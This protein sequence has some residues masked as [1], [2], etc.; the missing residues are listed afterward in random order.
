MYLREYNKVSQAEKK[1]ESKVKASTAQRLCSK[2]FVKFVRD[3][4]AGEDIQNAPEE[5]AVEFFSRVYDSVPMAF[6]QPLWL[7]DTPFPQNQFREGDITAEE[8]SG[9]IN[10]AR[11]TSVPSPL[12]QVTYRTLKQCPSLIPALMN[13][14]RCAGTPSQYLTDGRQ[15]L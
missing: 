3:V 2:N 5:A 7:P 11:S 8:I 4:L 14:S 9:V 13:L 1:R 6:E 12:N 15:G 10:R